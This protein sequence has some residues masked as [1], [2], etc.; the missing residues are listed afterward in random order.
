[1]S[2]R[3]IR[4]AAARRATGVALLV[5]AFCLGFSPAATGGAEPAAPTLPPLRTWEM[6]G[7]L[8]GTFGYKDNVLL[9]AVRREGSAFARAEADLLWWRLPTDRFEA[10]AFANA[11][12]TRFLASD[13]NPREFQGFARGELRWFAAPA[14][15]ATG[16]VEAYHLD[17]LFDLSTSRAEP[18]TTQLAVTGASA[19]TAW[20]W[21]PG[22]AGWLE[23][24]PAVQRD[25][26]RDGS[27]DHAQVSGRLAWGCR[28]LGDRLELSLAGQRLR[29]NYDTRPRHTAD[30]DPIGGADLD[31]D[32]RDAEA[33][34]TFAW[35][36]ARRWTTVTTLG[37]GKNS[38]NG[39][40]YFDYQRRTLRQELGWKRDTWKVRLVGRAARYDYAVQ[41]V[42]AQGRPEL[43]RK[44]ERSIQARVER[45]WTRDAVL[46][47]D[48][49]AERHRSNDPLATY[50]VHTTAAGIDW[51]F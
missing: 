38:D 7:N 35:N 44:D 17:Q 21:Q 50:R 26:Y 18:L 43:R 15:Q 28:W 47:A 10:L 31:F 45:A 3:R 9:S 25:R 1:M 12:L 27:D 51:A 22:P 34:L 4:P 49:Q 33:A 8:R 19:S 30:G 29:R 24:K 42:I 5:L 20:R 39:S 48:V 2:A 40:G 36:Q 23:F 46:F 41:T 11:G 16:A 14:L 13:D 6:S 32:Q 37:A